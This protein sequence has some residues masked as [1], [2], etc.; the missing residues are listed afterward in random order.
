MAHG[1]NAGKAIKVNHSFSSGKKKP[2]RQRYKG[3][4]KRIFP[5]F[6]LFNRTFMNLLVE[7]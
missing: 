5:D 2:P 1:R 3:D 7:R 6:F 4:I